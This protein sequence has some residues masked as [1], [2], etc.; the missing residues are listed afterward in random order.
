MVLLFERCII[1]INT[2]LIIFLHALYRVHQWLPLS[3]YIRLTMI[4]ERVLIASRYAQRHGPMSS[5]SAA[6]LFHRLRMSPKTI[7][8]FPPTMV[9]YSAGEL[10]VDLSQAFIE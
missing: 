4:A 10:P 3:Y 7:L 2:R 6:E 5:V 1:H 9:G 8:V